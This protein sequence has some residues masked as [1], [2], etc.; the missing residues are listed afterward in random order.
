[1]G[2]PVG[3]GGK[4]SAW[5]QETWIRSLGGEDSLGKGMATYSIPVFLT[6]EFHGWRRLVSPWSLKGLDTTE[7][8][9]HTHTHTH[10]HAHTHTHTHTLVFIIFVSANFIISKI[11]AFISILWIFSFSWVTFSCY[12]R[13]LLVFDWVKKNKTL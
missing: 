6:G 3:L 8:L 13:Y 1:M 5:V 2:Y 7:Q 10:T 11:S 4:E 12:F 9:T